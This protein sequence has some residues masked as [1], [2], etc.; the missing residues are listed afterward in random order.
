MVGQKFFEDKIVIVAGEA[1]PRVYNKEFYEKLS[2]ARSLGI[3][4]KMLAGPVFLKDT[5]GNSYAIKAAEDGLLNL[6]VV[7]KRA[8][9]HFRAN[10]YTGELYYEYPHQPNQRNRKSVHFIENRF[11]VKQYLR[12]A[13]KIQKNSNPF[14]ACEINRDYLL[15]SEETLEAI[16][17]QI[18]K[19]GRKDFNDHTVSEI[20]EIL[21][22]C[23]L[24][25]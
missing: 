13:R 24:M 22:V 4:V 9:R 16:K 10:F 23:H 17:K 7:G 3:L 14:A 18:E 21:Q 6:F 5:E 2:M 19:D 8:N 12:L 20:Q 1:L 25:V 11:E 15:V